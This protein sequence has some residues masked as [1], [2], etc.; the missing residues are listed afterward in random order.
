MLRGKGEK[1]GSE[2]FLRTFYGYDGEWCLVLI[3][4]LHQTRTKGEGGRFNK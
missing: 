3:V 2:F 1:S 4:L